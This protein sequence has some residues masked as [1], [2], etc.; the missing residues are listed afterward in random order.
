[1]GRRVLVGKPERVLGAGAHGHEFDPRRH[2][3]LA[4]VLAIAHVERARRGAAAGRDASGDAPGS[5]GRRGGPQGLGGGRGGL[6]RRCGGR[7]GNACRREVGHEA[8]P[9]SDTGRAVRFCQ[10]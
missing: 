2:R 9:G 10:S 7:E 5:G 1:M 3:S 4:V 8:A 6:G